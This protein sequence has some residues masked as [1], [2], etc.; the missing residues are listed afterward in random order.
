MMTSTTEVPPQPSLMVREEVG[1]AAYPSR[2]TLSNR[3][4]QKP[5]NRN[6]MMNQTGA[7][8][9]AGAEDL[10][11]KTLELMMQLPEAEREKILRIFRIR[12]NARLQASKLCG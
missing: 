9:P 3:K 11:Q 6:I 1:L 2:T 10:K 8:V 4:E 7:P 5:M 12:V